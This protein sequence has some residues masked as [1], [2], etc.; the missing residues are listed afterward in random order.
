MEKDRKGAKRRVLREI[1]Q[2]K[3]MGWQKLEIEG[4]GLRGKGRE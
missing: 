2:M 3:E 4:N 1:K